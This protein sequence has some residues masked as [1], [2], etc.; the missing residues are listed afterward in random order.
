METL[1]T[2]QQIVS[3]GKYLLSKE[4]RNSYK[5]VRIKGISLDE[6]LSQVNHADIENFKHINNG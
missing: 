6:R 4:R 3:F 1:F 5:A 2:E